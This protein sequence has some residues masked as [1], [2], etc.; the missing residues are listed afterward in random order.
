MG[1][2]IY[3]RLEKLCRVLFWLGKYEEGNA[4]S[5][6]ATFCRK[7]GI[8]DEETLMFNLSEYGKPCQNPDHGH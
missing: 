4:V 8:E 5:L 1:E 3:E 7:H 6:L 2:K